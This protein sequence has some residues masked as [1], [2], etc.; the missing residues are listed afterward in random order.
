MGLRILVCGGRDFAHRIAC[1]AA[2]ER[3]HRQRGIDLLIHGDA[4][5]ADELAG[6]WAEA[7]GIPVR[8]FPADWKALG[9]KAGPF[10]NAQ[11]L[12]EGQPDGVVAFPGGSGTANMVNLARRAGVKVWE[13]MA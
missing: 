6:E 4:T 1:F 2:L 8:R 12:V 11:M 5:G 10:R 7:E 3:L 9:K 13:P